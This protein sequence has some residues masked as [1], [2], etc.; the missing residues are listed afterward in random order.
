VR[1][2]GKRGQ[3]IG[4]S[5][6][7]NKRGRVCFELTRESERF[8]LKTFIRFVK[9]ISTEFPG[10]HITLVVAGAPTHKAKIVK[11]FEAESS[12]LKP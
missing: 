4:I 5:A 1:V 11:K 12:W 7:V 9:K 6:A 8:T 10:R 2:S 3:H